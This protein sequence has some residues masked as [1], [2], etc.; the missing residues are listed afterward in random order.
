M[1]SQ[2]TIDQIIEAI[3]NKTTFGE[4]VG[5]DSSNTTNYASQR[6]DEEYIGKI[7]DCTPEMITRATTTRDIQLIYKITD[8][9]HLQRINWTDPSMSQLSYY[10]QNHVPMCDDQ[11]QG[12][13]ST[14]TLACKAWQATGIVRKTALSYVYPYM[15]APNVSTVITEENVNASTFLSWMHR[16]SWTLQNG[17]FFPA[18]FNITDMIKLDAKPVQDLLIH[19]NTKSP[20]V[21]TYRNFQWNTKNWKDV[22]RRFSI[23]KSHVTK[24]FRHMWKRLRSHE[25]KRAWRRFARRVRRAYKDR[26]SGFISDL[27]HQ[28]QFGMSKVP[29]SNGQFAPN[30]QFK[31]ILKPGKQLKDSNLLE[32]ISSFAN[33]LNENSYIESKLHQLRT[34]ARRSMS[35]QKKSSASSKGPSTFTMRAH[36]WIRHRYTGLSDPN[37]Y[38]YLYNPI[39]VY[40]G[41][42]TLTSYIFQLKTE[43]VE[44]CEAV[45]FLPPF[46][47]VCQPP[48][49]KGLEKQ[50][51]WSLGFDFWNPQCTIDP[52]QY[53]K[54]WT[55]VISHWAG[56]DV[57]IETR[58]G[59]KRVFPFSFIIYKPESTDHTLAPNAIPCSLWSPIA[60][61]FCIMIVVGGFILISLVARIIA[62]IKKRILGESEKQYIR[63]LVTTVEQSVP[64]AQNVLRFG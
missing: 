46:N 19:L 64:Q 55:H 56:W 58:P 1:T 38:L 13:T 50:N 28:Q 49:L 61:L 26:P 60:V 20:I 36:S 51:I 17:S 45:E 8:M 57:W 40:N 27:L 15:N 10:I 31:H 41:L 35:P 11:N 25:A 52:F 37:R 14:L 24:P 53:V 18:D 59:W 47:D 30:R 12:V 63:N 5:M 48:I 4:A 54:T 34:K 39:D 3:N 7:P 62:S 2:I 23:L 29:G 44:N 16:S 43:Y 6:Q 9:S 32:Y 22:K 42:A 33:G 21:H